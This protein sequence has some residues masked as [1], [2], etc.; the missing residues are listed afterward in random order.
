MSLKR[1]YLTPGELIET[2]TNPNDLRYDL[3][4]GVLVPAIFVR[5]EHLRISF[6]GGSPTLQIGG[7]SQAQREKLEG[8][9]YLQRPLQTAPLDA[10][11]SFITTEERPTDASTWWQLP[12]E[13][14]LEEVIEKAVIYR[15]QLPEE[16]KSEQKGARYSSKERASHQ[17]LITAMAICAYRFDPAS[18]RSEAFKDVFDDA[19]SV[20]LHL[21]LDTVRTRIK[22]A[23][24]EVLAANWKEARAKHV[25]NG[26]GRAAALAA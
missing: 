9:F 25:P 21:D 19:D 20:G 14:A 3:M 8:M 15:S 12:A 2:G 22:E 24:A 11:F 6:A 23:A 16:T 13:M 5:G 1:P 7:D 10:V 17:K 4:K 18:G 26:G